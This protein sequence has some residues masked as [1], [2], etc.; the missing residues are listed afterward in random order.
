MILISFTGLTLQAQTC[1]FSILCSSAPGK[2][3]QTG[4][5]SGTRQVGANHRDQWGSITVP[6]RTFD[7][8]SDAG[9][10]PGKSVNRF[11]IGLCV[12]SDQAGDGV[13]R[14]TELSSVQ[15]IMQC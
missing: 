12:L 9:I 5:F 4:N 7:L 8:Y 2:P 6:Y 3:L 11:G 15:P 10:Q 14:S 1:I 13:L